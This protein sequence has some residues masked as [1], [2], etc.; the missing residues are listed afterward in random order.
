MP[1]LQGVITGLLFFFCMSAYAQTGVTAEQVLNRYVEKT[2]GEK[3]WKSVHTTMFRGVVTLEN[4][5]S[6]VFA[7]VKAPNKYYIKTTTPDGVWATIYRSGVGVSVH[8]GKIDT[9]YDKQKLDDLK[10][11]SSILP[12]MEY[13]KLMYKMELSGVQKLDNIDYYEIKLIS[14][15][16]STTWNYYDKKTG[17]LRMINY[18]NKSKATFPEYKEFNG[19]L[20]P[21]RE[22]LKLPDGRVI[23]MVLKGIMVNIPIDERLFNF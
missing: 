13:K 4:G 2:G 3:R 11:Q 22:L 12:D 10:L 20:Y 15:N 21:D 8:S 14:P 9:I 16:G 23:D 6:I 7:V 19:C 1:K 18:E 5:D 17:L